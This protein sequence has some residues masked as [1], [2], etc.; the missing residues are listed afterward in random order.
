VKLIVVDWM[1][2]VNF[3]LLELMRQLNVVDFEASCEKV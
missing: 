3:D 2:A 1:K